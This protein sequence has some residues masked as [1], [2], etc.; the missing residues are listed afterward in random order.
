MQVIFFFCCL[1]CLNVFKLIAAVVDTRVV[2]KYYIKERQ[3]LH[4]DQILKLHVIILP[5]GARNK[6]GK[7]QSTLTS[8]L[9]GLHIHVIWI[10][11]KLLFYQS[12]WKTFIKYYYVAKVLNYNNCNI[13]RLNPFSFKHT[14]LHSTFSFGLSSKGISIII[15]IKRS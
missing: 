12:I 6:R 4:T 2:A 5:L 3:R 14:V 7:E 15:P 9:C 1:I 13:S 10:S 11:Y 8:E